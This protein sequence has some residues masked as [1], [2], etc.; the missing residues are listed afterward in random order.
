MGEA[1]RCAKVREEA[2]VKQ[3]GKTKAA[4]LDEHSQ[5]IV[6][7]KGKDGN[8]KGRLASFTMK[9]RKAIVRAAYRAKHQAEKEALA[10]ATADALP[11]NG[12]E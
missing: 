8:R 2:G 12:E 10:K 5:V 1:K 3:E 7:G 11:D 9:M 6:H 4:K